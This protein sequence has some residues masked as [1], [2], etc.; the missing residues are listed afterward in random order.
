MEKERKIFGLRQN[1][2]NAR[3]KKLEKERVEK[4][5]AGKN[6]WIKAK[7]LECQEEKKLEKERV[8]KILAGKNIWRKKNHMTKHSSLITL[9]KRLRKLIE[10]DC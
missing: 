9:L 2:W 4:I 8:E 6:I 5:L 1:I 10:K 7:Y 3:K